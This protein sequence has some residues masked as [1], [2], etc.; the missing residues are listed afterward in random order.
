MKGHLNLK[1]RICITGIILFMSLVFNVFSNK[2]LHP[3]VSGYSYGDSILLK[4]DS[5]HYWEKLKV[6][7]ANDN[8]EYWPV[9]AQPVPLEGAILPFQRVV[10]F[11]G[12]LFSKK[13]GV[14]GKYPP[15]LL[16]EKLNDEI[17]KWEKADTLTPV[18]PALHYVAVVAQNNPFKDST[19]RYRMPSSQIDSVLSIAR[20]GN[21]IVFLD[22]QPGLSNV[23]KEVPLLEKYLMLPHVHLGLDPE[24]SMKEGDVPGTVKGYVTAEDINFCSN[25]LKKLVHTYSLPPKIFVVHRFTQAMVR[26]YTQIQLHPEVQIVINMDGWGRP[27]LKKST[28][29]DYIY[30]EPIQFTG[31]K[32]FYNND[33]LQAP[34][35]LMIPEEI[36]KLTPRPVYIQYQ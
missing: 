28:Y 27:G 6:L 2:Y 16:W 33:L 23:Q 29:R 17:Q 18:I 36:L 5:I 11:Y 7:S 32:L 20:M 34:H 22:I 8:K 21:A 25:Y 4:V 3:D 9:S 12:N 10:A 19:Y 30:K 15:K 35:R 26:D 31:F 24:F 14:L 13:M 1:K